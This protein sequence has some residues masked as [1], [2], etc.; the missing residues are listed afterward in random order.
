[1][2]SDRDLKYAAEFRDAIHAEALARVK[3][4]YPYTYSV[5]DRYPV[6]AYFQQVWDYPG[7]WYTVVGI[8]EGA[9]SRAALIEAIVRDTLVCCRENGAEYS[10][11]AFFELLED[12]PDIGCDYR[13]IAP[14][15]LLAEERRAFPYRGAPSH[16]LALS[17]AA[18]L[19][20]EDSLRELSRASCKKLKS[21]ALFAPA[22]SDEWPNYRSAFFRHPNENAYTDSDFE[23]V[24]AVLFPGGAEGLEVYR[25]TA[26]RAEHF[27]SESE[28]RIAL[29]LSIYDDSIDRFVVIISSALITL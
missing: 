1:M 23:R 29:C 25:W 20:C 15:D 26:D 17:C 3:A 18:E 14:A 19:F 16:R 7:T 21:K 10:D 9:N 12:Y 5:I 4:V 22:G 6:E 27:D 8:P 13:I 28:H 2:K 24:N 11:E